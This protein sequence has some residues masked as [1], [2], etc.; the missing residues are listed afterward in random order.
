MSILLLCIWSRSLYFQTMDIKNKYEYALFRGAVAAFGVLPYRLALAKLRLVGL[1]AGQVPWFRRQVVESNLRAVYPHFNDGEVAR[2]RRQIY[3][4]LA[5]T[6]AETFLAP[7]KDLEAG[8]TIDPGWDIMDEAVARGKGVILAT[9]HLGNF[10]LGGRILAHRYNLLDVI[11]TQRNVPF[12]QYLKAMRLRSGIETVPMAQAVK[13]VLQHLKSQGVVS[14]L[15]DQDAGRQGIRVPFMGLPASTWPGPARI[16]IRTGA[17]VV[18]VALLRTG[19]QK[20]VLKF[21]EPLDSRCWDDTSADVADFTAQI[22]SAVEEYIKAYPAQWFWVHRR[23][24]GAS[25]AREM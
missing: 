17:P 9:A 18:P 21:G 15:L 7:D 2:M 10:E 1:M 25:E 6:V 3:D 11:K 5:H 19:K 22:C 8:V 24:K 13:P 12:D 20:F 4:H 14:L 23:W 16:A